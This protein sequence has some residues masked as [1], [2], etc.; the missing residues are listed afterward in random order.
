MEEEGSVKS[1][2]NSSL[3]SVEVGY[4]NGESCHT[5]LIFNMPCSVQYHACTS[6]YS[7]GIKVLN[8]VSWNVQIV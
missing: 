6:G 7:R 2:I 4:F 3:F 1:L 5:M 8:K